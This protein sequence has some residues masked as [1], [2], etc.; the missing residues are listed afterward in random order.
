MKVGQFP[1]QID[2]HTLIRVSTIYVGPQYSSENTP[3][4]LNVPGLPSHT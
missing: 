3:H 2:P 1:T 4:V